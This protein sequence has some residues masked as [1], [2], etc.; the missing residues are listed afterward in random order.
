MGMMDASYELGFSW[1]E[2]LDLVRVS[3]GHRATKGQGFL[4]EP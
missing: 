4:Q 3:S 1:V 2:S